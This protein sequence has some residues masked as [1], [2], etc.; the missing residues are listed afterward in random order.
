MNY[1]ALEPQWFLDKIERFHFSSPIAPMQWWYFDFLLKDGSMLVIAFVPEQWWQSH[2]SSDISTNTLFVTLRNASGVMQKWTQVC[3]RS[4][5][6]YS[7]MHLELGKLFS[8]KKEKGKY[9]VSIQMEGIRARIEVT[10]SVPS[11]AASPI[12]IV[13]ELILHLFSQKTP[14]LSYV[15]LVPYG[16]AQVELE[17]DGSRSTEGALAYYEQ[18]RFD[19]KPEELGFDGWMWFHIFNKEWNMFGSEDTY[20]CINGSHA[21]IRHGLP[22]RRE[23]FTVT[24]KKYLEQDGRVL[25]AVTISFRTSEITVTATLEALNKEEVDIIHWHSLDEKQF[26][27]TRHAIANVHIEYRGKTF[28]F[29]APALLETCRCR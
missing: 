22:M 13:P 6:T 10:P 2:D 5:L 27:S 21:D 17:T 1:R 8:I 23:K 19:G 15:S 3:P 4:E 24:G 29:S 26:W 18:G 16:N 28:N 25:Q 12:G 14:A 9:L 11:F 7:N 20:M